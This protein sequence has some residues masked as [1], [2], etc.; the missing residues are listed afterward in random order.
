VLRIADYP[1]QGGHMTGSTIASSHTES[2]HQRATPLAQAQPLDRVYRR[3]DR[4][5]LAIVWGLLAVSLGI[6]WYY[7]TM[8][9]SFTVGLPMAVAFTLT[10]LAAPGRLPTRLMAGTV[11]MAFSALQIH[12]AMGRTEFHFSVFVLLSVLL[13]YRDF[14]PILAGAVTIALHHLSFSYLQAW[15]WGPICFTEPG[16]G[17]VMLHAAFV[18]AQTAMLASL[19][20]RMG[21]DARAAEELAFLATTIR[22]ES[23]RL[24]LSRQAAP[25]RNK[26]ARTFG[27]TL[28]AV[29]GTLVQVRDSAREL[30]AAAVNILDGNTALSQRTHAQQQAVERIVQGVTDLTRLAHAAADNATTTRTLANAASSV[31]MRGGEVIDSVIH[32][33]GEINDSSARIAEIVGVIDGIAFQT[34]LLALNAS[35]EAARAGELGRGFAVVAGEVRTLAQRSAGA[36]KEIRALISTSVDRAHVGAGLVATAGGTMTEVVDSIGKLSTLVDEMARMAEH[37]RADTDR[38]R[39]DIH[40]IDRAMTEN[41]QH[42]A[43]T[44]DAAQR[45]QAESTRLTQAVDVF[46]LV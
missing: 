3:A 10:V 27:D 30:A 41:S 24:T 21:L 22:S 39:I 42:V 29:R 15:G 32:T 33:M 34:N 5:M 35:V 38:I 25:A 7:G 2:H 9:A 1:G 13:A 37:Q 4:M 31:A 43:E 18:V 26:T 8:G 40:A 44:A 14:R 12:Q 16:L 20:W 17:V 28:D 6:G 19:A 45:Q 11:L 36:A 46:R 23:G